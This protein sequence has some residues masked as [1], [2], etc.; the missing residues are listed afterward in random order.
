M[1]AEPVVEVAAFTIDRR[2]VRKDVA[3]EM[4]KALRKEVKEAL[5][6][7]ALPS[8]VSDRVHEF[9]AEWYPFVRDKTVGSAGAYGVAWVGE[10]PEGAAERVQ[11]FYLG[12][13]QDLRVWGSTFLG[14][15]RGG[16]D[17]DG[18]KSA[19]LEDEKRVRERIDSETKIK[20]VMDTV[21]RT[22]CSVFYDRCVVSIAEDAKLIC[23]PQIVHAAYF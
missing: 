13:E 23:A 1:Q 19:R 3:K 5:G 17:G 21:E 12:L 2:L 10:A 15:G 9:T 6:A 11:D 4:N 14:R 22:V 16:Y 8:W 7:A 20:E 18:E